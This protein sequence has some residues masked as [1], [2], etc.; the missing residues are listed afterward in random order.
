MY[1]II[2]IMCSKTKTFKRPVTLTAVLLVTGGG[3]EQFWA[4]W[5]GFADDVPGAFHPAHAARLRALGP[6]GPLAHLTLH[7][8]RTNGT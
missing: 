1:H 2:S 7:W 5:F 4:V 8:Q 6:R 3:V